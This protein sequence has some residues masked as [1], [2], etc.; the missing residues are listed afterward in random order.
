MN[1]PQ[2]MSPWNYYEQETKQVS[3]SYQ[4]LFTTNNWILPISTAGKITT[5]VYLKFEPHFGTAASE[6]KNPYMLMFEFSLIWQQKLALH[7]ASAHTYCLYKS[8]AFSQA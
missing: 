5:G 3:L 8:V 7:L 1:G 6:Y 2:P 4:R